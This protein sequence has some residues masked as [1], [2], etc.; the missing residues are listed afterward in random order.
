MDIK[1]ALAIVLGLAEHN[2]IGE[3]EI[4][5]DYTLEDE[6]ARQIEA[7][8]SIRNFLKTMES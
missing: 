5:D 6:Q 7:V 8:D 3:S 2:V 1:E 4:E